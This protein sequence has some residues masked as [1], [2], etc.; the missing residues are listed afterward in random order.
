LYFFMART[1]R[2]T[3][4]PPQTLNTK[5]T[6]EILRSARQAKN[7]SIDQVSAAINIRPSMLK[8]I[9]D[10][11]FFG[12]T[13]P[14][15]LKG[16]IRSY[17][18]YLELKD[19]EILPFFRREYDAQAHQQQL[20]QPLAP[21]ATKKS[22]ITP[23]W[24]IVGFLSLALIGVIGYA[25]QQYVSVALT[26]QLSLQTPANQTQTSADQIDVAGHTDPDAI[27][28]LNGQT[29]PLDPSGDFNTTVGLA[30]GANLLTFQATNK[31]GKSTDLTRT[32]IS[33]Q[34]IAQATPLPTVLAATTSAAPTQATASAQAS[35]LNIV[36]TIGP[37]SAWLDVTIDGQDAFTGILVPGATKTFS[38]QAHIHLKTGNAGSTKVTF[39]G[40]DSIL[41]APNQV[42]DKDYSP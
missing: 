36:V 14:L 37:A 32:I 20:T 6:G 19:E 38:G 4:Q 11:Q 5:S 3:T 7:L 33:H 42:A 28:T 41:G 12:L 18:Q 40:V 2:S 27:L 1:I 17:A 26:P 34:V 22:K 13:D 29:L 31:L 9:E 35:S 30:A 23:G 16:F 15:Y 39:K 24:V 21:I 25:Y 10:G 8:A